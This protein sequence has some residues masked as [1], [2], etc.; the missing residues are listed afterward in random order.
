MQAGEF[1]RPNNYKYSNDNYDVSQL[2]KQDY[3]GNISYIYAR[4][5]MVKIPF[6][7]M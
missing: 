2:R 3:S 4:Q 7:P 1:S 6:S 5:E